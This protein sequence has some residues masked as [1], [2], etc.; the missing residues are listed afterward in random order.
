MRKYVYLYNFIYLRQNSDSSILFNFF[1]KK[2]LLSDNYNVNK[3]LRRIEE[4]RLTYKGCFISDLEYMDPFVKKFINDVVEYSFGGFLMVD[5]DKAPV[6]FPSEVYVRGYSEE[7]NDIALQYSNKDL[8]KCKS[9]KFKLFEDRVCEDIYDNF[10][11]L[12]LFLSS[13]GNIKYK[14]VS[15]QYYFPPFMIDDIILDSEE[16]LKWIFPHKPKKINLV[17]GCLNNKIVSGLIN[18]LSLNVSC[19]N[20]YVLYSEL[21]TLLDV[22]GQYS[23]CFIYVWCLS[24]DNFDGIHK[25]SDKI[26]SYYCLCENRHDIDFFDSLGMDE[27]MTLVPFYNGENYEFCM[28]HLAYSL[29]ELFDEIDEELY[30]RI[31]S[32]INSNIF[33]EVNVDIFGDV[34][35]DINKNK[36][37]CISYSSLFQIL[38]M[39]L[40]RNRNWF[41]TRRHLENCMG[42]LYSDLCPPISNFENYTQKYKLCKCMK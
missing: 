13:Y 24:D 11:T 2:R 6:Q 34:Y 20:I 33:G 40:L 42:C 5:T 36:V 29:E 4:T 7:D 38:R 37:G 21:D 16:I 15:N 1:N 3:L 32:M 30:F 8:N 14:N 25:F 26:E 9:K 31:N 12:T 39:E 10:M 17:I 41:F 28:H 23:N 18:I 19:V 27:L 22:V 35:T